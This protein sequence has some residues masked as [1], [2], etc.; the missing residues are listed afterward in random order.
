MHFAIPLPELT[1]PSGIGVAS[2]VRRCTSVRP[3]PLGV[4]LHISAPLTSPTRP[5]AE[6]R[7]GRRSGHAMAFL[8]PHFLRD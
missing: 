7:G 8:G 5:R 3:E 4:R 2:A 1:V 6:S